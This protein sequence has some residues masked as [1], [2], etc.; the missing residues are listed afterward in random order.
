MDDACVVIYCTSLIA[1]WTYWLSY[2][3]STNDFSLSVTISHN[4]PNQYL[5]HVPTL[6]TLQIWGLSTSFLSF[7]KRSILL[8]CFEDL[9]RCDSSLPILQ[10]PVQLPW[11][12][13]QNLFFNG[14][15]NLE[16]HGI[17]TRS[18]LLYFLPYLPYPNCFKHPTFSNYCIFSIK[19]C[20]YNQKFLL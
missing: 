8:I 18:S 19:F 10:M 4:S 5:L 16:N 20:Q 6:H 3:R 14:D 9:L 15:Q 12:K 11:D 13:H 17:S 1:M 2:N 7:S